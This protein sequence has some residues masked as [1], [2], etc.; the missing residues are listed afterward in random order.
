MPR[1]KQKKQ[2]KDNLTLLDLMKWAAIGYPDEGA[3]LNY[4]NKR[5]GEPLKRMPRGDT[6]CDFIVRELSD[7]FDPKASRE[8]QLTEGIRA[9]NG[10]I[11]DLEGVKSAFYTA[12][13]GKNEPDEDAA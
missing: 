8:D 13:E 2:P 7:T 12:L 3:L 4:Y 1:K 11:D 6:L 9:I 10:A 5:T